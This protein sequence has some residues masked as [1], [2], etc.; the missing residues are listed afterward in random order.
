MIEIKKL[1]EVHQFAQTI[2]KLYTKQTLNE[3]VDAY[4]L[5]CAILLLQEYERKSEREFFEL[6]YSIILRLAIK[7][8]K[9]QPLYDVSYNFGF[10]PNV[11]FIDQN[12]LL[13]NSSIQNALINYDLESYYINNGY[14][15]TYEQKKTRENILFSKKK[16][17]AYIAPTS[18]GKSSLIIQH[19][20]QNLSIHRAVIIVPT[21]SLIAQTYKRIRKDINDRKIITHEGMYNSEE[22]FIGVLTQERLFRLLENNV[23]LYFD[24]IYVD[25]AHNI[26]SNN[27]RN[28]ILARTIQQC[29]EKNEETKVIF[30]S[31]FINDAEN[32]KL[33]SINEIDE[34]RISY[35][36]KE[37]DIFVRDKEGIVK[38]YDRFVDDFYYIKQE[39]CAIRYIIDTNKNKNFIFIS[40]PSKIERFA[41]FLY[42]NTDVITLDEDLVELQDLLKKYV[43]PKFNIIKYLTHGIIYL[44]AKIPDNIKEYLEFKFNCSTKIKYIVA[45]MVI[46]EGIN[47]PIDNLII[48]DTWNMS[49]EGL[50]NLI[51]RVN[52]LN[53]IFNNKNRELT[54]LIPQVHFVDVPGFTPQNRKFENTIKKIYQ[55]NR[56]EVRNPLLSNYSLENIKDKKKKLNIEATNKQIIIQE[57]L[58]NSNLDDPIVIFQ[59]KLISSGM[60]QLINISK[61]NIYQ[62]KRNIECC[63][64]DL[65]VIEIVSNIF[66]KDIDIIDYEFKRL[67]NSA[68]VKF[69]KF[70]IKEMKK[71]NF[72]QLITSQLRYHQDRLKTENNPFMYVGKGY[73]DTIKWGE[74]RENLQKVYV[75]IEKKSETELINLI[76]VKTKIEQEFLGFQYNR[77]VN[78]LHDNGYIS[79]SKFNLEIY[80]TDDANK[81]NLL[82]LG[83]SF[84]L[85]NILEVNNQLKNIEFDNYKNIIANQKLHEFRKTQNGLIQYEMEKY[86]LF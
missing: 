37:P 59:K 27:Y 64:F 61:D 53:D 34:Q 73:G 42:N 47:L 79:D 2:E 8:R 46:M 9:Y 26:F 35:N 80:G 41:E 84:P 13:A 21:K 71:G 63:N 45:N 57:K 81:I 5:G 29:K 62:L 83:I 18:M 15:E 75:D 49:G 43:H 76:I 60:N 54:K 38:I 39:K 10:Y 22:K 1:Y 82:K 56:D 78:F 36:I 31:P 17:I 12:N 85:L 65:D 20:K 3:G 58:Y 77:A 4:I 55:I 52:R 33:G 48:C 66:T 32:L 7:F 51:G 25:E 72:P 28:I 16:N 24:C 69:Y 30:L 50:Q 74:D 19:I 68:A 40:S 67:S 44:H 86:I 11:Q 14:I 23:K 6:A 70:F